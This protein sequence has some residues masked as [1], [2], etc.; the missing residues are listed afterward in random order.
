[1]TWGSPFRWDTCSRPSR[2]LMRQGGAARV[3]GTDLAVFSPKSAHSPRQVPWHT[4]SKLVPPASSGTESKI[5]ASLTAPA[6]KN[7]E[8]NRP[9]RRVRPPAAGKGGLAPTSFRL[10]SQN[11]PVPWKETHCSKNIHLSLIW[12]CSSGVTSSG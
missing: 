6:G 2:D 7:P 5:R 4:L 11:S 8:A 9:P 1:M 3:S 10:S 12:A